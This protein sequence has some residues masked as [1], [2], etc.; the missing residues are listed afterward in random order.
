MHNC[1][2]VHEA[3]HDYVKASCRNDFPQLED[4]TPYLSE[5][6]GTPYYVSAEP[7]LPR[8]L[9]WMRDVPWCFDTM[10]PFVGTHMVAQLL[11]QMP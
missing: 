6:N 4:V 5:G 3:L 10:E 1:T 11:G 8:H 9:A 7:P 2:A